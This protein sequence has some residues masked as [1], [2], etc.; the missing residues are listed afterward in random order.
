VKNKTAK[1]LLTSF[2]VNILIISSISFYALAAET[3][4]ILNNLQKYKLMRTFTINHSADSNGD[5]LNLDISILLGNKLN[6]PYIL[7]ENDLKVSEGDIITGPQ[8]SYKLKIPTIKSFP[9]GDTKKITVENTFSTGTVDYKIDKSKV[10]NNF[11]ELPNYQFYLRSTE[12]VPANDSQ[13]Q[14]KAEELTQGIN[15]PYDKAYEIFKYVNLNM[16]YTNDSTYANKGALNALLTNK[17]VCQDYSQ[18]FVA[19]C[20]ASGIPART[21]SGYR[22]LDKNTDIVNLKTHEHMWAEFYMPNYG[23]VIAEPTTTVRNSHGE[24]VL[25][26][27]YFAKQLNLAEHVALAYDTNESQNNT[28]VNSVAIQ[29][30]YYK[31]KVPKIIADED[32]KLYKINND[33]TSLE[34]ATAAVVKAEGSNLQADIDSAKDLVNA[35]PESADKTNLNSRL[36][37]VQKCIDT[38][39][40]YKAQLT[41]A[42]NAVIKAE[43][44]K[45]QNDVTAARDLVNV[46][47][48]NDKT[49][50]TARLDAVQKTIDEDKSLQDAIN[51][52]TTAVVKAE[53]SKLQVD[54]DSAKDLVNALPES[55]DETN[56][57]SRLDTVQ[58]CIDT[59]NTYKVQLEAATNAVIKAETSKLQPDV[60]SAKELVNALRDTDKLVLNN[61]L[62]VVQKAINDTKTEADKKAMEEQ[63]EQLVENAENN[64]ITD[65][66]N[67]ALNI[68]NELENGVFKTSLAE[69]LNVVLTTINDTQAEYQR[70]VIASNL[71]LNAYNNPTRENYNI[72][73]DSVNE[74]QDSDNK[75]SLLNKLADILKTIEAN[76]KE[77][78]DSSKALQEAIE[79][80][81]VAVEA[82]E[83]SNLQVNID[84]AKTLVDALPEGTDKAN[85]NNRLDVV[86][87]AINDTKTAA[88]KKA[89][90]EQ[91]EQLVKNAE[92]NPTMD[93]YKAA[94]NVVNKLENGAFK[95]SLTERLNV[96]LTTINN[97]QAEYRKILKATEDVFEAC[98]K[99]TRENYNIALYSVNRLQDCK[100]KTTLTNKLANV[101]KTIEVNERKNTSKTD[102]T[103]KRKDTSIS[104]KNNNK[105]LKLLDR[106]FFEIA[107][108]V[109]TWKVTFNQPMD[110][111]TCNPSNVKMQNSHGEY[112][113]CA[114]TCN[115]KD[116]F[117]TPLTHYDLGEQ[118]AV[119]ISH[120]VSNT[121]GIKM[122][123]DYYFVFE[124]K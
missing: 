84:S 74:L 102:K 5:A 64:P 80:A 42:T 95:T 39:N 119:C 44:S 36:D 72:A 28:S 31:N 59:E 55:A 104:K 89:M 85:L 17:G 60:N 10:T 90:K 32:I 103:H 11:S 6:S 16:D 46:L 111:Q 9:R 97:T 7:D 1:K 21:V 96:V 15:N 27:D 48:D 116:M 47:R 69:R 53:N 38:E 35:L 78:E 34:T 49:A 37:T 118:Y 70:I 24:K 67:A 2:I 105:F 25:A 50:L 108:T 66:Y 4:P 29:C 106:P 124:V 71:V 101:L 30:K 117:I 81:T 26:E 94:L 8:D 45:L 123:E 56:L 58:K 112:I 63:A 13:I 52:A 68:V 98:K 51:E 107:S 114:I 75:T 110:K 22:N 76:E 109:K 79:K 115:G 41:T 40:A 20:R 33:N 61:R 113:P 121:R 57:N 92:N 87:E 86:Q 3:G 88:E 23:W 43:S 83:N 77:D 91:A 18:L 82:A 99:P 100:D 122:L 120:N 12:N 93:N 14:Q 19:L 54:I 65:N 62:D 73:L